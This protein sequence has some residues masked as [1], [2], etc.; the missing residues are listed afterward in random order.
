MNFKKILAGAAASAMALT[1]MATAAS[2]VELKLDSSKILWGDP[3][4]KGHLRIEI[5]NAYGSTTTSEA[6]DA[7]VSP[8][9]PDDVAN[10]T[11]IS[12][13]FTLTGAPEGEYETTLGFA[14]G[15][16]S[17]QDWES[18]ITVTG[19]GTYT[20]TSHFDPWED[21]E[22]GAEIPALANGVTVFVIDIRGMGKDAGIE[23]S[24]DVPYQMDVVTVSDVSIE[25]TVDE[26]AG[27]NNGEDGDGDN[28]GDTDGDNSGNNSGD[29]DSDNASGDSESTTTTAAT[30]TSGTSASGSSCTCGGSNASIVLGVLAVAAAAIVL[31]KKRV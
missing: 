28:S 22:T 11:E 25:M 6:Y 8:I 24:D 23:T 2:A 18:A 10:V 14:D 27:D 29:A 17:A 21:E 30:T 19:D 16:W 26:T 9:N 31:I 13:T 20:I 7:A 5:Y 4:G 12:V 15:S 1:T 3:E